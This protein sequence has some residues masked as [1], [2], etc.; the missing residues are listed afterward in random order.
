M[1]KLE[2]DIAALR[3]V[4]EGILRREHR[5]QNYDPSWP[6]NLRIEVLDHIRRKFAEPDQ[7]KIRL[8]TLEIVASALDAKKP[9]G[10]F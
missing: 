1:E 3:A 5:A 9:I 6:D 8:R 2:V 10:T 4:V 7:E